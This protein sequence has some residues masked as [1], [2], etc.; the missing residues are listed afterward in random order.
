MGNNP[1]KRVFVR[2]ALHLKKQADTLGFAKFYTKAGFNIRS[3]SQSKCNQYSLQYSYNVLIPN[4]SKNSL[5][6]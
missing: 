2:F 5:A 3:Q 1:T 4:Y 6:S